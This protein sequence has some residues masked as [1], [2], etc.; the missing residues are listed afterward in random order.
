MTLED[1]QIEHLP[2]YE[3]IPDIPLFISKEWN[4]FDITGHWAPNS[5]TMCFGWIGSDADYD[6]LT[7]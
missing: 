1:S 3:P 4:A 2:Y 7:R 6:L 5:P